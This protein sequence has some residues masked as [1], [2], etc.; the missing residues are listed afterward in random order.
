VRAKR[1]GRQTASANTVPTNPVSS[2]PVPNGDRHR[3][4]T[5]ALTFGRCH[6]HGLFFFVPYLL[7]CVEH[8]QRQIW[9]EPCH[10]LC[11]ERG[12]MGHRAACAAQ[13][14]PA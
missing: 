1:F 11:D 14:R 5:V 7:E 8:L 4:T 10:P 2:L 12:K 9:S 13:V 3:V 6:R